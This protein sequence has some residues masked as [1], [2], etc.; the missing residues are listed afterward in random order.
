MAWCLVK[1]KKDFTFVTKQVNYEVM[2]SVF[3]TV[4]ESQF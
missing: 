1:H 4:H 3:T 2:Y